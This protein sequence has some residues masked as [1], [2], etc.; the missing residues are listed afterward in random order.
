MKKIA[1]AVL[2]VAI[3][4]AW[5]L[6]VVRGYLVPG[7]SA[8]SRITIGFVLSTMQEE[9]YKKDSR[10]VHGARARAGRPGGIHLGQERRPDPDPEGPGR[11][12]QG[13]ERDGHPAG[14]LRHGQEPRRPLPCEGRAGHRLRPRDQVLRPRPLRDAGQLPRRRPPG[15]GGG[16][17]HR[18]QR[19]L[20]DPEGNDG[21]LGR[22]G[23]HAGQQGR[24]QEV[25]GRAD[26]LRAVP[27]QLGAERG[28]GVD[29]E[30]ADAREQPDRRDPLQQQRHGAR[31]D[32]GPAQGP[33]RRQG[34]R[35]RD[36]TPIS[37]TAASC[38]RASRRSKS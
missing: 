31:R 15:R 5:L 6:G 20:R 2:L 21:P 18:R 8:Q 16:E 22:G 24:A 4:A 13:R 10:R 27:P 36:R 3:Y 7:R 12:H 28:A 14:Q 37:T 29:R 33:A 26:R 32:P 30:R 23:D 38:C 25:P 11:A 9:R 35:R 1:V 34:G 19:P 17:G